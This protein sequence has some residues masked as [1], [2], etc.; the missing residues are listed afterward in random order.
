M[1]KD[2]FQKRGGA[3]PDFSRYEYGAS[4]GGPLVRDKLFFFGAVERFEEPRGVTPV[5]VDA[6]TQLSFFPDANVVQTIPTPYKDTLFTAKFDHRLGTNQTMFYRFAVQQNA[7]NNDQI[8]NPAR[9][10]LSGGSTNEN[11]LYDLVANHTFNMGGNKL[12]QFAFHC[13]I[14]RP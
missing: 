7:S 2:F 8:T 14:K 10:D 11:D 12:N 5:H 6:I 13:E 9:T 1:A 3:K 4:A